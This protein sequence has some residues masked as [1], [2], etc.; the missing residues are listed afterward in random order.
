MS[1][2]VTV[3]EVFRKSEHTKADVEGEAELR[4]LSP[5]TVSC[6][7]RETADSWILLTRKNQFGATASDPEAQAE[8]TASVEEEKPGTVSQPPPLS[9]SL[10]LGP[11]EAFR[12]PILKAAAR[13]RLEPSALACLIDAEAA[14]TRGVW[15]PNSQSSTSSAVGLTQF[16]RRT[17]LE[18][19][20]K[21]GTHL[22]EVAKAQG[23]V[24]T[25][26]RVIAGQEEPLL[27]LR[28]DA[29]LSIIAAGDYAKQNLDFLLSQGFV[30]SSTTDDDKAR[31]AYL[32]HH[33]GPGGAVSFLNKTIEEG[34]AEK[35]LKTNVGN[36][37][38][39]A[40]KQQHP[41]WCAAYIAWFDDYIDQKIQPQKFRASVA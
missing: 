37:K 31:L 10:V 5:L 33:E 40:R 35:L 24:D 26:N 32:A 3:E 12:Q 27:R 39:V 15:D 16:L 30:T 28:L 8:A 7:I 36:T 29:E 6:E 23:F 38:A 41:T 20:T 4:K 11:N 18:Q 25:S 9:G 1:E 34:R 2:I 13:C 14:K 19:A 21:A 17:W 22:N